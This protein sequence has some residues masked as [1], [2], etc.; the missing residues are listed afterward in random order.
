M[1]INKFAP[2]RTVFFSDA[3]FA[4]AMTLL[5]LE[6]KLPS[7]TEAES[8]G[9]DEIL[10]NRIPNFICFAISFIVTALF[11]RAHMVTCTYVKSVNNR[12]VWINIWLLF[13]VVVMPFTTALYANYGFMDNIAFSLYC[14]NIAVIGIFNYLLMAH[15]IKTEDLIKTLGEAAVRWSK[16][17]ALIVPVVFVLAI[18]LALVAPMTSRY[19]FILIFV[20]QAIGDRM[21]KKKQKQLSAEQEPAA[22]NI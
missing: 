7:I 8:L 3:V 10:S 5:V 2:E 12:F 16:R 13:F 19:A 18:V 11:W 1:L 9:I 6:I 14:L 4:I 22:E 20:L 15:V 21:Y 17:R